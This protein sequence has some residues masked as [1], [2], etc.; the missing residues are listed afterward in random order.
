MEGKLKTLQETLEENARLRA[1]VEDARKL[2]EAAEKLAQDRK[3]GWLWAAGNWRKSMA[4]REQELA[5]VQAENDAREQRLT[6]E[7]E[8]LKSK[9]KAM[10]IKHGVLPKYMHFETARCSQKAAGANSQQ[11]DGNHQVSINRRDGQ[12]Q[13][14]NTGKAIARTKSEAMERWDPTD[15][16]ESGTETPQ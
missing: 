1:E 6:D 8:R 16:D 11:T 4:E 3:D 14:L 7:V 15:K 10:E 5:T 9:V 12:Q 13:D 2:A